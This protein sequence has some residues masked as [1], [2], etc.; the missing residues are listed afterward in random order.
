MSNVFYSDTTL[1]VFRHM[2]DKLLTDSCTIRP[3]GIGGGSPTLNSQG[4]PVA[5]TNISYPNIPCRLDTDSKSLIP[6]R[7]KGDIVSE[8]VM[9]LVYIS[10]TSIINIGYLPI[11]DDFIDIVP[12]GDPLGNSQTYIVVEVNIDTD[13]FDVQILVNK[14]P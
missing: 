5:I 14:Q 10:R 13:D 11:V 3:Q 4:N 2:S 6:Q 9:R 8:K 12:G 7:I 1:A